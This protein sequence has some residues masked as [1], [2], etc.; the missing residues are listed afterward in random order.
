PTVRFAVHANPAAIVVGRDQSQVVAQR[1]RERV[2][3]LAELAAGRQLG[4]CGGLD[5][6]R[7]FQDLDGARACLQ[8]RGMWR[9]VVPLEVVAL[10]T[11]AEKGMEALLPQV[12]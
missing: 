12:V 11:G 1:T 6:G 3:V 7:A 9:V 8:C 5:V 2:T 4:E 10:P